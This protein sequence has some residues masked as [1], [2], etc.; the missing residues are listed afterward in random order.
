MKKVRG[1][2]PMQASRVSFLPGVCP[3][4]WACGNDEEFFGEEANP[5][6]RIS[7]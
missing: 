4:L 1:R 6:K 7:F 2:S 3:G 5:L